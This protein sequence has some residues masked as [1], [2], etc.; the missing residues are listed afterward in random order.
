MIN[1]K[2][3]RKKKFFNKTNLEGLIIN[4]LNKNPN[5]PLNYKQISKILKIKDYHT[6]VLISEV[7]ILLEKEKALVEH[8]RGFY[9]LL[10]IAKQTIGTVVSS[11]YSGIYVKSSDLNFDVYIPKDFSFFCLEGDTVEFLYYKKNK[12]KFKGEVINVLSREKNFFVGVF[13]G[14]DSYGF[15][16]PDG[17]IPFDIFI[18]QK[19]ISSKFYNKKV[20]VKI[21]DW[22]SDKKN[23]IGKIIK[24]IG[25]LND[26]VTEI[27]SILYNYNLNHE[28]SNKILSD[29]SKI[30]DSISIE[31]KN[32][33]LNFI[34]KS[35]FT[36]DPDDAKDFDDAISVDFL[37]NN[38]FEVGVH[39]A[40][41][42]HYIKQDSDLDKEALKRSNSIYLV[43]RVI[44]MIPE[45][46]SNNIC[47]L[48][49]NKERLCF[50][51][52]FEINNKYE[53]INYKI[54]KTIIKSNKRFSYEESQKILETKKGPFFEE[55]QI[56]N[57]IS[58]FFRKNRLKNGSID[59]KKSEEK[60]I[61]DK[62][63]NPISIFLKKPLE[64]NFLIEEFM[65]LTNKTIS[66]EFTLKY[67]SNFIYRVHEKP[68][69]EKIKNLNSFI[70]KLNYKLNLNNLNLSINFLINK[71]EGTPYSN[72]IKTLILRS[73]S[74]ATYSSKNIGHFGLN[75]TYYSHFTSPIRRYSDLLTHRILFDF[76]NKKNN[77]FLLEDLCKHLTKMEKN[78]TLAERESIKY[79][80]MK[81][82]K[83]HKKNIYDGIISG[84]K[85]WGIYVEIIENKCEGLIKISNLYDDKYVYNKEDFSIRGINK[86]KKY[87]LGDKIKIKINNIN[88]LN[89][90]VY[91][92]II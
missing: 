78:T 34:N 55:L 91:F 13:E 76:L 8:K 26:T 62:E 83:N 3:K 59:F 88:I 18:P 92:D 7:L 56:L 19:N 74:K 17:N 46:L 49:E 84:I 50:S 47:S 37:K 9:K 61:L 85:E 21:N 44:P 58:T 1:K 35:T 71:I 14:S 16:V 87:Q 86:N 29:L 40:D 82:L 66:K 60:F 70:K 36:I 28:F 54:S 45:K 30:T 80:K 39:I 11:N 90:V 41:V 22:D 79:M 81:Y 89:K 48:I 24:V 6:K 23:P 64:T 10:L 68:N 20:L 31:E 27:D 53:I 67:S 25:N 77:S 51:V 2:N 52:I 72:I 33:R 15:I 32:K 4:I 57:K 43:D 75:F 5:K 69:I 65:L 12:T 38:N 42:S 73:M 63:K